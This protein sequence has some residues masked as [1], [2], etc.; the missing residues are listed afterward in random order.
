[1]PLV[2]GDL[3]IAASR[4]NVPEQVNPRGKSLARACC[5]PDEHRSEDADRGASTKTEPHP[6]V[7]VDRAFQASESEDEPVVNLVP[8]ALLVRGRNLGA[9]VGVQDPKTRQ[10][11][12]SLPR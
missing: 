11:G 3:P 2:E 9:F 10:W 6:V 8:L 5:S 1:M 7:G 4:A 12:G